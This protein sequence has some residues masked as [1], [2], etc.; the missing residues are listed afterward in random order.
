MPY[1]ISVPGGHSFCKAGPYRGTLFA[2]IQKRITGS[3]SLLN[4]KD[5][6]RNWSKK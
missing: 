2:A 6:F 4:V 1:L 5:S 3:G